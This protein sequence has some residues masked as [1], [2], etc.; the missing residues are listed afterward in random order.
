ME[1][2]V[3][4]LEGEVHITIAGRVSVFKWI[5]PP[6]WS[7]DAPDL[8]KK[9]S[10]I[11]INRGTSCGEDTPIA[12]QGAGISPLTYWSLAK[13]TSSLSRRRKREKGK[14]VSPFCETLTGRQSSPDGMHGGKPLANGRPETKGERGQFRLH[15]IVWGVKV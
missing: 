6:L 10:P 4:S 1:V 9:C 2:D 11:P 13:W 14:R 5:C 12:T 15:S 8:T 3:G 7:L